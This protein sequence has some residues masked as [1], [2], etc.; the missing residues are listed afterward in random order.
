M[1][2]RWLIYLTVLLGTAVFDLVCNGWLSWVLLLFLLI[3]PLF[4]LLVSLPALFS[5]RLGIYCAGVLS[6]GDQEFPRLGATCLLPAPSVRGRIRVKH[7]LTGKSLRLKPGKPLPAAH[8][9]QLICTPERVSVS[10]Y[11]GLF[12][13]PVLHKEGALVTV[14]PAPVPMHLPR[15]FETQIARVWHPKPGGGFAENHELRLYR[16]GDSLNQVH[17]KLSAKTGKLVIREAM[18]PRQGIV[19]LILTA[20]GTA[21]ELDRK[22]GR[23]LWVGNHLLEKNVPFEIRAFTGSGTH[24]FSITDPAQLMSALDRLLAQPPAADTAA[25]PGAG[26]AWQLYIG[27]EAD[28][29]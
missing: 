1:I 22:F 17:W 21:E 20:C 11:L 6:I 29:T 28:E 5:V 14:R 18:E 9:G 3:L 26:R 8:C 19:A 27:G 2:G 16:P 25:A 24:I 4:S 13:F 7:T 12:R 15:S 10:D 23:L